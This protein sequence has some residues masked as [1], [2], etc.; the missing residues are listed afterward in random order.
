MDI[1]LIAAI[2]LI[3]NIFLGKQRIKYRKMSFKWLVMIH[4]SVP[5]IVLLRLWLDTSLYFIPLFIALAVLGQLIGSGICSKVISPSNPHA[6]GGGE[7]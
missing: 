4:G 7:E 3:S 1:V 5:L 2:A 6:I